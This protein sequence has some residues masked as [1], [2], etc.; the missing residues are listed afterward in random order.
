MVVAAEEEEKEKEEKEEEKEE[1][2][3]EKEKD[4]KKVVEEKKEKGNNGDDDDDDDNDDDDDDDDDDDADDNGDGVAIAPFIA[5]EYR[6]ATDSPQFL[7]STEP[8]VKEFITITGN[9]P[10]EELRPFTRAFKLPYTLERM[11]WYDKTLW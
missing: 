4:K 10:L 6:E 1:K 8:I 2:K 9:G 7:P 3:E 5:L 11:C